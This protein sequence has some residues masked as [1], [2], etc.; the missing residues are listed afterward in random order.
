[1][2]PD[3]TGNSAESNHA[4]I[5]RAMTSILKYEEELR[6]VLR[7]LHDATARVY[8]IHSAKRLSERV[9]T[10]LFQSSRG[11]AWAMSEAKIGIRDGHMYSPRLMS[12]LDLSIRSGVVPFLWFTTIMRDEIVRFGEVLRELSRA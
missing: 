1:M 2:G 11:G 10:H 7:K 9:P 12:R 8:G 4:K 6:D 5:V 3:R